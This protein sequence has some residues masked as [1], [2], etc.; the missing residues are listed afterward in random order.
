MQSMVQGT[1]WAMTSV[2]CLTARA[3]EAI[4]MGRSKYVYMYVYACILY[5]SIYLS[6]YLSI[7][8]YLY[9]F[10]YEYMYLYI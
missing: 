7:Y 2:S 1:T 3:T 8:I 9:V 5:V 10:N 4:A 6:I